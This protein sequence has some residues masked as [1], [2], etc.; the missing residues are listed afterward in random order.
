MSA[1]LTPVRPKSA[2]WNAPI[3]LKWTTAQFHGM[4]ESG[5]FEGRRALLINGVI[6]EQ[7]PMNPPHDKAATLSGYAF[8]EAFG[9]GWFIREQLPLVFSLNTDPEPD[10]AVVFGHPRDYDDHP[11]TASLVLEISDTSLR[12][13]TNEKMSLYA[14]AGITD[15]WVLDLNSRELLIYRDPIADATA[16]HGACYRVVN[17]YGENDSVSPLVLPTSQIAVAEMLP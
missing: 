17:H 16:I 11:T 6:L 8:R 13:D 15:Y 1:L 7:G 14:A 12:F 2:T 4:C 5:Q 10:L 3:P 9:K